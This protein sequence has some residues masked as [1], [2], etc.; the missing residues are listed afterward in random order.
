MLYVNPILDYHEP[1]AS[2]VA[3]PVLSTRGLTLRFGSKTILDD[4]SFDLFDKEVLCL[5]GPPNCGKSVLTRC[6]NRTVEEERASVQSG[7]V[8][9]DRRDTQDPSWDL[10]QIRR[11][12]ALVPQVANPFPA[13]IWDNI[14]Y[15]LKLHRLAPTSKDIALRIEDS[16]RRVGIWDELK[17]ELHKKPVHQMPIMTQRLICIARALALEPRLLVLDE[18]STGLGGIEEG[19]LK[20]ILSDLQQD[21]PVILC[22]SSL[23]IAALVADRIGHIEGGRL[24]EIDTA[25]LLLTNAQTVATQRYVESH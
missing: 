2:D 12:V 9:V 22:T 13:T 23:R 1:V 20:S 15:V 3:K 16:L 18:P 4:I 25:E 17:G 21:M 5:V 14:A 10:P 24:M 19:R 8:F 7:H 6:L 11:Q